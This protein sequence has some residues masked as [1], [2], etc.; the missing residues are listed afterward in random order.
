MGRNYKQLSIE[1]RAMIQTQLEMGIKSGAVAVSIINGV[2]P[3]ERRN[4]IVSASP[5]RRRMGLLAEISNRNSQLGNIWS[6]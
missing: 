3:T 6:G 1:E 5:L 2:M 4:R